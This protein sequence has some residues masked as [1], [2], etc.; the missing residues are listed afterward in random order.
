MKNTT[1]LVQALYTSV[2]LGFRIKLKNS[3][4]LL[5]VNEIVGHFVS[6]IYISDWRVSNLATIIV[7]ERK[8]VLS[9]NEA[10]TS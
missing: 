5:F 1:I 10:T 3:A 4:E 9:T 8:Y 2:G 7:N 6:N